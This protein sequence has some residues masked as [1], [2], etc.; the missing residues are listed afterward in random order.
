MKNKLF[1]KKKH[2]PK[3]LYLKG[4]TDITRFISYFY[5]IDS[6]IKTNPKTILEVGIGNKMVSNYLKQVGFDVVACDFNKKLNPDI[7]ADIKNLPFKDGN[8][9][10]VLACEILEHIPFE[11]VQTAV[12]ELHRV[13]KKNIIVSIPYS[14]FFSSFV[15][16]INLALR[17]FYKLLSLSLK[18]PFFTHVFRVKDESHEWLGIKHYWE[19]GTKHYSK[20]KVKNLLHEYC[21]IE[22]EFQPILNP[23]HYF[24]ILEKREL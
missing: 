24:F 11:D 3:G 6:V 23:Y 21:E 9:D 7:V 8:F 16:A 22:K 15:F 19:M 5:Q 10:V 2:P 17:Y 14:C 18:F 4:Y 20:K 12:S 1:L 13:S